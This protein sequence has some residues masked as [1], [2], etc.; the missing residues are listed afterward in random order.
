MMALTAS[1]RSKGFQAMRDRMT[2]AQRVRRKLNAGRTPALP[3]SLSI[4]EAVKRLVTEADRARNAMLDEQLD[5]DD[6][7]LGLIFFVAIPAEDGFQESIGAKWIG[8]PGKVGE[9]IAGLEKMQG[10][11]KLEFLGIVWGLIDRESKE[12]RMW[13]KPLTAGELVEEKLK[14]SQALFKAPHKPMQ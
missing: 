13:A 11:S 10:H 2:A 8:V 3:K 5:P 12:A 4:L 7:H 14:L 9:F 1:A 6:V